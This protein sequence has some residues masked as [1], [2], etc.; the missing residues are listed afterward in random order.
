MEQ[1]YVKTQQDEATI[2]C[3]AQQIKTFSQVH[4]QNKILEKENEQLVKEREKVSRD[5]EANVREN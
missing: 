1:Y 3:Q 4:H 2:E 5:I